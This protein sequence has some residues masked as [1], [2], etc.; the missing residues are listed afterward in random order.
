MDENAESSINFWLNSLLVCN[1]VLGREREDEGAPE[2]QA[3]GRPREDQGRI[4]GGPRGRSR[5]E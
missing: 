5:E 2:G 4:K 3:E 1:P